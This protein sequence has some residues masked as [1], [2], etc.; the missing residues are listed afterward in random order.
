MLDSQLVMLGPSAYVILDIPV[1]LLHK[2]RK[3]AD[4]MRCL[5]H[6]DDRGQMPAL[7]GRLVLRLLWRMTVRKLVARAVSDPPRATQTSVTVTPLRGVTHPHGALPHVTVAGVTQ[8]L[9]TRSR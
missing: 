3:T 9:G 1:G 4:L 7:A 8:S 2:V 6:A 5:V